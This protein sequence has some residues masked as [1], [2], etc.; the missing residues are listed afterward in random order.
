MPDTNLIKQTINGQNIND[1]NNTNSTTTTT[2]NIN[3]PTRDEQGRLQEPVRTYIPSPVS[4]VQGLDPT[5]ADMALANADRA[6]Q[7]INDI[8]ASIRKG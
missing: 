1:P 8:L 3:N 2:Q 4:M 5:A 6:E 7:Q